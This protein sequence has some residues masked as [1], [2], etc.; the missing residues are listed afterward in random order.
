MLAVEMKYI[1]SK[2]NVGK[3]RIGFF[4]DMPVE[5]T[6]VVIENMSGLHVGVITIGLLNE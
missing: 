2:P 5:V 3:E 1:Y 4:E 6:D